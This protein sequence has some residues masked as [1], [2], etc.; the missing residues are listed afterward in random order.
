MKLRL[1]PAAPDPAAD[2][3]DELQAPAAASPTVLARRSMHDRLIP[4]LRDMIEG[5]ELPPGA[6]IS[7]RELC[8][9]F[10]VSRTPLREA[11][12]VLASEGLVELRPHRA[13]LVV[14]VDLAEI[15]ATFEVM[16]AL[17]QLAASRACSHATDEQLEN[18]R[19]MHEELFS[20]YARR[21]RSAYYRLNQMIHLEIIQ[22]ANNSVLLS[23]YLNLQTRI[24]RARSLANFDHARWHE[25]VEEHR[26][27]LA[28][29]MARDSRAAGNMLADHTART[30]F[31][32]L[33]GLRSRL[34]AE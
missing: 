32:V 31:A 12:K 13:P 28:V 2:A 19:T 6:V 3:G 34:E 11:L 26:A 24:A 17:E 22:M 8:E 33:S 25:S 1:T 10:G 20:L 9:R 23:T 18:L 21:D 5:G 4:L 30:A 7:E 14:D 15:A 29:L 16:E 27:L